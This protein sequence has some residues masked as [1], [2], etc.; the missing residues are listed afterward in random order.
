[1]LCKKKKEKNKERKTEC[2]RFPKK[3]MKPLQEKPN[4]L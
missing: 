1:M 2:G 3:M 4:K